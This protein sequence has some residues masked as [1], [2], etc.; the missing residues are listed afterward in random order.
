[1]TIVSGKAS[2]HL[3]HAAKLYPKTNEVQMKRL[4][5][6]NSHVMRLLHKHFMNTEAVSDIATVSRRGY[7]R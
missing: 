7:A 3:R 1:M 6:F 4:L 2:N 5:F